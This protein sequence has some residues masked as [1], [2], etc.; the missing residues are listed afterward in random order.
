MGRTGPHARPRVPPGEA[1]LVELLDSAA[2]RQL[3]ERMRSEQAAR[4]AA[5][6]AGTDALLL[7]RAAEAWALSISGVGF[8]FGETADP[9]LVRVLTDGDRPAARRGRRPPRV[10]AQHARVGARPE[11]RRRRARSSS[12]TEALTIA[13]R[14]GDPGLLA[15]ALHARRLAL[16][17]RDFL[18]ER[19][20]LALDAIEHARTAGDLH[21]ELT[22]MLLAMQDLLESGRVDEQLEMLR[23]FRERSSTLH[24]PVYD[25]YSEFLRVVPDADRR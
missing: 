6:L 11:R 8:S 25:V 12:A 13:R 9:E 2:Q 20:P 7:A 10:A 16:W 4:R 17:R 15:S 5:E 21:L 14:D 3:G 24:S 19:L 22:A 23:W 18:D 1:A